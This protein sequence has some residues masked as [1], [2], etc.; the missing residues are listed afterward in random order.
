MI[1]ATIALILLLVSGLPI[2]LVFL[3]VNAAIVLFQ[4]GPSGYGMFVNSMLNTATTQALATIPLFI[5]MGEI[6]FRAGAVERLFKSIQ[7]IVGFIPGRQNVVTMMLA[8]VLSA[9]SGAS[10][11]VAAMLGRTVLP[12]LLNQ[13]YPR[14]ISVGTILAGASLAPIVPPSVLVI[15]LGT[16]AE[17]SIAKL[18]MAGILPGLFLAVI[19]T[20]FIIFRSAGF[21]QNTDIDRGDASPL[22]DTMPLLFLIALVL[23]AILTGIATPT[24]AASVGVLGSL[25]VARLYNSLNLE[26]LV[27]SIFE[28]AKLGCMIILIMICAK[29][30]SQLLAMSGIAGGLQSLLV[31]FSDSPYLLLFVVMI[32]PFVLCMLID[33][34]ALLLIIVPLYKSLMDLMPVEPL[35]FWFLLLVNITVGGITPPFGYTLFALKGATNL[36]SMQDIYRSVLPFV[37]IYFFFCILLVLNP[38]IVTLIPSLL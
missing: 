12:T 3:T 10:M 18:L 19:F 29:F 8:A 1:V 32:V 20:S 34:I 35:V 28:S 11:A 15:I 9:L 23:G 21:D 6:I 5:L 13:G 14:Q 31:M 30:F 7:L 27:E 36:V 2:F 4:I 25:C 37:M 33:Q 16:L 26:L 38:W 24:E 22:K 17:E